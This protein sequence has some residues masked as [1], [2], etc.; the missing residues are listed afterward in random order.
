MAGCI[1]QCENEAKFNDYF[2]L[3][4]N[5]IWKQLK[6]NLIIEIMRNLKKYIL[7][8]IIYNK[9]EFLII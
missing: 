7:Y 3:L 1:C 5:L 6:S 8:L 2:S 9:N 4:T